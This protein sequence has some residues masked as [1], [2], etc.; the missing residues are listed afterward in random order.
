MLRAEL[1]ELKLYLQKIKDLCK[2][3]D[4]L[5]RSCP[6]VIQKT[7]E[8]NSCAFNNVPEDWLIDKIKEVENAKIEPDNSAGV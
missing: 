3:N 2:D 6:F 8:Y 7:T 5:C 4:D 1:N